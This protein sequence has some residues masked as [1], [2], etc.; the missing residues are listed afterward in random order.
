LKLLFDQN[1]S[2]K[3]PRKLADLYPQSAH[4]I[5]E[6]LD[7]SPDT[8]L[9]AFAG[10]HDFIVVTRDEDFVGMD[11][12]HGAPPKTIWLARKNA[13]TSEYERLLRTSHEQIE[14]F[15]LDTERS[16]LIIA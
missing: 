9:R 6:G 15:A 7:R 14:A 12:L 2:R 13:S 4:V 3:L 10:R 5:S 1:L 16:L 11:I 8:E